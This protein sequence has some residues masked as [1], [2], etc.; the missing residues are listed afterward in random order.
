[1]MAWIES[2]A[3]KHRWRCAAWMDLEDLIQE[4]YFCYAKC[5]AKYDQDLSKAHLMALTKT[6]YINRLHDLAKAKTRQLDDPVTVG[7]DSPLSP[8]ETLETLMPC[9]P[10]AQTF[11]LL[12]AALPAEIQQMLKLLGQDTHGQ[13][14][15]I[16]GRYE[17]LN[18]Y[19]W[20]LIG[21]QPCGVDLYSAFCNHFGIVP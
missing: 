5:R 9:E 19:L 18:R 6:A 15:K 7:G 1:M 4:G 16:N 2:T 13:M 21:Q 3:R 8:D 10:E 20:G 17:G 14:R 12:L 11:A